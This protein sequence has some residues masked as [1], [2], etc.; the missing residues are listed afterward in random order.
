[1][2]AKYLKLKYKD[3]EL[4]KGYSIHP[5]NYNKRTPIVLKAIADT[6]LLSI[7]AVDPLIQQIPDFDKKEWVIWG[8]NVVVVI[9]KFIT[10]TITEIQKV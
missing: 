10:K 3:M 8:W 2:Y 1:M 5:K 6:L 7:I 9:F 4:I